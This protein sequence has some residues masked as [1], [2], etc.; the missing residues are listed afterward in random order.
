VSALAAIAVLAALSQE[1]P[2]G[3][4]LHGEAF[5]EGPRRKG[6]LL[7]GMGNC[8]LPVTTKSAEAQSFFNQ[9]VGQIHGFYYFEAERSFRQVAAL[10]PDCAMAYWGM[11]MANVNN[12]KRAKG[13]LEKAAK[14][15]DQAS[16][17][18]QLWIKV[19]SDYYAIDAKEKEKR[20]KAYVKGLEAILHEHPDDVEAK[21]FL[22]WTIWSHADKGAP[23]QSH[24]AVDTMI[25]DVLRA[26]PLHPGAHHYRIHLWDNEKPARA[27]DSAAKFGPS[28]AGVAHAWHMPGHTYS[29]LQRWLDAAWQQEASAR[30]DH[31]AMIRDAT[32]PYQIHNYSHNNQW[33]AED[34]VYVGRVRDAVAV[35]EN[36]IEI[37]RHPKLNKVEDG[38][39]CA[40]QGRSRLLF[41]LTRA[42]LWEEL[43]ARADT[44]LARIDVQE[45][46]LA[47][48]RALGAAWAALGEPG[49]VQRLLAEIEEVERKEL[50]K[51]ADE[52]DAK[53]KEEAEKKLKP[54]RGALEELRGRL[55]LA[56]GD[57]KDALEHLKK[58]DVRKEV[59]A[60]AHLAA[61]ERVEAEQAA[62][63]AVDGAKNQ[64]LPL[65]SQVEILAG[66]GKA[67]AA[68]AAAKSLM[69]IAGEAD[70]DLPVLRRLR[71]FLEKHG[72]RPA[73][74]RKPSFELETLGP[75]LW[76]PPAAKFFSRPDADGAVFDLAR[77]NETPVLVL[78]YLGSTCT[79]CVEQ[80]GKFKELAPEFAKLH[81]TMVAVSTETREEIRANRK[82]EYPFPLLADPKLEAFKLYGCF[83]DFEGI[84]L[85]GT[86][87]V[88]AKE[89]AAGRVRWGE[90]SYTPFME[91]K[92]LLEETKRLL[93]R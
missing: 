76:R 19:L 66:L 11:A 85:H 31:A 93:T 47:R 25:A 92:F 12:E 62:K 36:L 58:A 42:E 83:D 28:E 5:N 10:D 82:A 29:K 22:A 43:A 37:P 23:I 86:F 60:R 30:V 91:A 84:P 69:E 4:S 2:A 81:V 87:L 9:G 7:E 65:A 51:T 68:L 55:K 26:N 90:I 8:V 35:A 3:H 63:A 53:K 34:L 15:K 80:L 20:A 52:K 46:L 77:C 17:R 6:A 73:A 27:L 1:P 14:L 59:L 39:H 88:D 33:L 70:P 75:L 64:V 61:G 74:R 48:A 18:E 45:D 54:V 24:Q 67:D 71:P 38:G 21:A 89:P 72:L 57:A 49:K 16:K 78:F 41:A 56:A 79:H 40:R 32:M 50:A 13:F 44:S